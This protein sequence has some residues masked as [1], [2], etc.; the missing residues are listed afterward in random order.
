MAWPEAP[1]LA[2]RA[3]AREERRNARRARRTAVLGGIVAV[4]AVTLLLSAFG[5]QGRQLAGTMAPAPSQRLLPAGPPRPQIVAIRDTLRIQLPIAQGRVTA[6]GYHA[7]GTTTLALD[8]IGSQANAGVIGRL[9][10]RLFGGD[11]S[12]LRYYL[13]DGGVG[14][15]TGGLDVGAPPETDV[16]APVDGTVIAI[17]DR[18]VNGKPYG[19]RMELQPSGNPS[20]VVALA[21]VTPDPA[22]TVGS[23]VTAGRTKVGRVIDMSRVEAAALARYTQDEGH[24]VHVEVRTAASLARP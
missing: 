2:T 21:N 5:T 19:V 9:R 12:G 17:S 6:I 22:L 24:H 10:D 16:Y 18:I 4:A 8:P 20:L 3:A 1:G 15:Q 7:A 23:S 13:L 11:D 14:A